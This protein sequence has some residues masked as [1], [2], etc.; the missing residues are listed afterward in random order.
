MA[1]PCTGRLGLGLVLGLL[2]LPISATFAQEPPP[3]RSATLPLPFDEMPAPL[4]DRLKRIADQPTLTSRG[5]VETVPCNP[6]VYGWFLDHPD[7]AVAA[8]RKIGATVVDITDRGNGR[9]GWTDGEGSDVSWVT[10]ARGESQRVWHAEGKVKPGPLVAAIPFQALVVLRHTAGRDQQGRNVI[11]HQAEL[12]LHT[13]SKSAAL[14][15][16]IIGV[17]GP[18]MAEQY[19]GQVQTFFSALPWYIEQHPER[20]QELLS[21]APAPPVIEAKEP[22]TRPGLFAPRRTPSRGPSEDGERPR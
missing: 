5:P 16:K 12:M 7:R 8:W 18:R 2:S 3:A 15:A 11:R 10:V 17:A 22:R 21:A 13:D 20:A 14:I 1:S 6:A 9:F 4:R 19:I